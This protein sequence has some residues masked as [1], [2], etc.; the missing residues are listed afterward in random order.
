[1]ASDAP[2]LLYDIGYETNDWQVSPT[3]AEGISRLWD[4]EMSK[5]NLRSAMVTH[6]HPCLDCPAPGAKMEQ[7][8]L[9]CFPAISD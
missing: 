8:T 9:K 6:R 5:R 7:G 2:L 3:A 4:A 1:M